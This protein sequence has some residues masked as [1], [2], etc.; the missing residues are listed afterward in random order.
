MRRC[1]VLSVEFLCQCGPYF[2]RKLKAREGG[3]KWLRKN[4]VFAEFV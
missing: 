3:T 1:V 2:D 4:H